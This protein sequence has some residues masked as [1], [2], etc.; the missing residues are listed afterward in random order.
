MTHLIVVFTV[1]VGS[2]R[3]AFL[4]SA[5]M[6]NWVQNTYYLLT[7]SASDGRSGPSVILAPLQPTFYFYPLESHSNHV[8]YVPDTVLHP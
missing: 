2:E 8:H 4:R 3:S 5:Y 1:V 6:E 7:P